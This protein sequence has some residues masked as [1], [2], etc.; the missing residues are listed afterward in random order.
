M[1]AQ[2]IPVIAIAVLLGVSAAAQI[3]L[4]P[5]Q[6]PKVTAPAP[7]RQQPQ[8]GGRQ[9]AATPIAESPGMLP[10]VQMLNGVLMG[11]VYWDSSTIG[12]NVNTPCS[13]FQVTIK[14]GTPPSGGAIG[15]EQFSTVGTYN[16]NF[17]SVGKVGKYAVCQYAV[18]HL[19]EGKDL[20]VQ[21]QASKV[22]FKTAVFPTT[23]PTANNPNGPIKINGGKCNQLPPATPSVS[24]LGSSWWTCGDHAYNVNYLMQ[25]PQ[26]IPGLS[27]GGGTI[28]V[29]Q[30]QPLLPGSASTNG[31]VNPGPQQRM[32]LP[33]TGP[34]T[35]MINS[36]PAQNP[37]VVSPGPMD[38]PGRSHNPGATNPGPVNLPGPTKDPGA[39]NP[40]PIGTPGTTNSPGAI[41]PGPINSPQIPIG[42]N[43]SQIGTGGMINPASG[44]NAD[45]LNPQP[46]P[47][48]S[49]SS[50]SSSGRAARAKAITR[51][52]PIAAIRLSATQQ[53]R[54]ITNAN[55]AMQNTQIIAVLQRQT[56]AAEGE[57]AA[58]KLSLHPSGVQAGMGPAQTMAATASGG[59]AN[60]VPVQA[61][62]LSSG[63][64]SS[65]HSSIAGVLPAQ[66]QSLAI[67]CSRDPAMRVL[68]VSG[69]QSAAV[70][71]QDAK[72]NFYT[73]KGCSFG[74]PGPNAKAY[75]YSQG[76]FRADFQ[77][78][79]WSDN[80]I[81]LS[82]NPNLKG[83]DDQNNVTLVI[84]RQ[85]GKQASK[86]GFR[87]YAARE[88]ILLPNIPQRY[89][90]LYGFRLDNSVTK[91][92]KPTYTSGSSA[93]VAPNLPGLSA[94]VQWTLTTDPNGSIVGGSDI[95]DFSHLHSTFALQDA[96]MEWKDISCD[97]GD[98]Q[99]A[100]SN[101]NWG[102]DW[103][104]N[105]G[106]KVA[107][108]GQ[109]CVPKPGSCGGA[110]QPDCFVYPPETNYGVDVWVTG[111]RGVDPWTG[112]PTA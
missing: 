28:Q 69:G 93:T 29:A 25:P 82:I 104:Q 22:N 85:D 42:A 89:F 40:G 106:V 15:F 17:S 11:Y 79:Q 34:T 110:F 2:H 54:K 101:D 46:L 68:T 112:K 67:T 92:W 43:S 100:S 38:I 23:P 103:Y 30:S 41:N 87:F 111:P 98:Y 59:P 77:I 57:I 7:Q 99:F 62:V 35:G 70:F 21:V 13:G 1:R 81:K 19:P 66:F 4:S 24:T 36:G 90:S 80:W 88:T 14:Q 18:N 91:S 108:Q 96:Q 39:I 60:V 12:Y 95:Y 71:T 10:N 44:H 20:Q 8:G 74:D 58:M 48:R 31:M 102:I 55:A 53:S 83:I 5:A 33:A 86:D 65:S 26:N 9:P 97:G 52:G 45:E 63:T 51:T 84:Q 16:N 27:G 6:L 72:Y 50:I 32:L 76:T 107:W 75:I 73:I 47:P 109:G 61:G 37:G 94:E 3:P 56:Q 64:A 78:E 105:A 49:I